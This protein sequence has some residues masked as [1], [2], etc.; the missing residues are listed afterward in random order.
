M[1]GM[2]ILRKFVRVDNDVK[3]G[4]RQIRIIASDAT[5]DLAK[6]IMV[7]TGCDLE[8]YRNNPIILAQHD[9]DHPIGKAVVEI[10]NGRVEA[11]IDFP[12]AGISAKADE[13]CGLAKNDIIRAASVGFEGIETEPIKGGG[14]KYNKWRL[15]EISLVSVPCN[16][17]ALVIARSAKTSQT[18]ADSEWKVG[19]SRNLTIDDDESWD[20]PE[21]E[22]SIF[23][24][25]NFDGDKPDT[26]FARKGFLVYDASAP[27]LKGSYKLP[28]AKVNDGRLVALK[29]GIKAAASRLPQTDIPDAAAK[30][31]RAVIDHYESKFKDDG[32]ESDKGASAM[33]IK[34]AAIVTKGLYG[35]AQLAST[36]NDL[37]WQVMSST[38]EAEMEGDGSKVPGMLAE[39]LRQVA[40]AFLAMSQEE[41]AELLAQVT[42]DGDKAARVVAVKKIIGQAKAF[43]KAG[44]RF[45][46]ANQAHLDAIDKCTKAMDACREKMADLHD[47]AA[48]HTEELKA[49]LDEIA[50]HL[51]SMK[52]S[53]AADNS[54][55]VDGIAKATEKMG[56]VCQKMAHLHDYL[57]DHLEEMQQHIEETGEHVKSMQG[58]DG[59]RKPGADDGDDE[60][61][62]DD[63]GN[64]DGELAFDVDGRKR[65]LE[66]LA[67]A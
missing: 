26:N 49:H 58:D 44:R 13:Y 47:D 19:A 53:K 61:G 43:T 31:A 25:C 2:D 27:A 29:S 38:W 5:P 7:P 17:G 52:G 23:D 59:K 11:L 64:D 15:L 1:T 54:D 18:K 62:D 21:A 20:G 3:L 45:S 24:H 12:P 9:P 39:G 34:S 60:T 50:G 14:I 65:V 48:G 32:K 33:K 63:S 51:K 55:A 67:K 28:F 46:Q 6:D 56:T 42:P 36:L 4:E 41:V 40:D 37:G 66:L 35:V 22:K 57:H 8:N 16:P 30:K 10:F